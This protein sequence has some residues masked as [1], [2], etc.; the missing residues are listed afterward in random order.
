MK[1]RELISN[2]E[3]LV[4]WINDGYRNLIR[5]KIKANNDTENDSSKLGCLGGNESQFFH[6]QNVYAPGLN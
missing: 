4:I 1:V 6:Q 2:T 5:P 3:D